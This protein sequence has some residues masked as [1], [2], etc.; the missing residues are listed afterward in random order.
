MHLYSKILSTIATISLLI[1]SE[2]FPPCFSCNNN[3]NQSHNLS[4]P[5]DKNILFEKPEA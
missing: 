4:G 2:L 1:M 3:F 5:D